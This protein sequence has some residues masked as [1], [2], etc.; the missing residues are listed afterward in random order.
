M[1]TP[2]IRVGKSRNAKRNLRL[3]ARAA[4]MLK[5]RNAGAK[6]ARVFPGDAP[7]AAILGTS[8]DHQHEDARTAL[9]L[10]KDFVIHS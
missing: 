6:S 4:D 3:T 10:P 7:E 9:N 1:A 2:R 5:S 8:L